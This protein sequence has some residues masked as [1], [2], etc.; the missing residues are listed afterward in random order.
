MKQRLTFFF[1][2]IGMGFTTMAQ[3]FTSP[4][5][6]ALIGFH[7]SLVDYNSP[8]E[9]DS[10]SLHDVIKKGDIFK[11]GK[12]AS[13]FTVSF[14]KGI[15]RYLDFSGKFNG[16]FYDYTVRNNSSGGRRYNNEFGSEL[17]GALNIH[18]LTDAHFFQPFL[19]AG[20]GGGYY[21]NKYGW[22][23]P[24]GLGFQFNIRSQVYF[25]LQDY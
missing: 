24:L 16:I 25:L 7:F 22:Y 17:E 18:P 19:T 1:L 20:I 10:T 23:V 4:V 11:P 14:W 9:I 13:A 2:L 8:T 15:T 21:T 3:K 12:Q 5:K 6:P